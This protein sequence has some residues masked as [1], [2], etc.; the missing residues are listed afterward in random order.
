GINRVER[1]RRLAAPAQAGDDH[2]LVARDVQREVFQVVLTRAADAYEFF[3][4][5][6]EFSIQTK[7]QGYS[8]PGRKQSGIADMGTPISDPAKWITPIPNDN[9]GKG[10]VASP[11]RPKRTRGPR[12]PTNVSEYAEYLQELVSVHRQ[13]TGLTVSEGGRNG[14]DNWSS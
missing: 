5:D 13:T 3:A 7:R 2:Q 8:K 4:H 9:R 14:R 11:R 6:R 10:R 12:I 1:E